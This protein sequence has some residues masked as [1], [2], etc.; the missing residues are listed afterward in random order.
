MILSTLIALLIQFGFLNSP[1][2][3]DN[4]SRP[5]QQRLEVIIEDIVSG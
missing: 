5:E 2:D 3:W 4:L 1:A